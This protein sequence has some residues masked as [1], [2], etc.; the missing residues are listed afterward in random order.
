MRARYP[1]RERTRLAAVEHVA[2]CQHCRVMLASQP[3]AADTRQRRNISRSRRPTSPT[4]NFDLMKAHNIISTRVPKIRCR[5]NEFQSSK[6]LI[7]RTKWINL[8]QND[9]RWTFDTFESISCKGHSVTVR[10]AGCQSPSPIECWERPTVRRQ[11]CVNR[12]D[13]LW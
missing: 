6:N 5:V 12:L 7:S 3:R 13:D 2:T 1:Q 11:I 10:K 9:A 8:V 4:G